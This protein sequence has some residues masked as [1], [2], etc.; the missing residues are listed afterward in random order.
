VAS[1]IDLICFDKTGTLTEE[2]LDVNTVLPSNT[3]N[4]VASFGFQCRTSEEMVEVEAFPSLIELMAT[5]HS[6]Q[7]V[8]GELVGDPLDLKMFEF[9][10]WKLEEAVETSDGLAPTVVSPPPST[11]PSPTS[12]SF[13]DASSLFLSFV[14]CP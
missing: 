13:N 5:C 6:I 10:R 2:G 14:A 1:R 12:K 4:G 7:F 11:A 8:N 9:T 3:Q